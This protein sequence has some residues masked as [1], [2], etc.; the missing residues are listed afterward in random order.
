V[1]IVGT[2]VIIKDVNGNNIS[3]SPFITDAN[4]QINPDILMSVYTAS[5]DTPGYSAN[6]YVVDEKEDKYPFTITI[7][8]SGYQTYTDVF[9]H[10]ANEEWEIALQLYEGIYNN[11]VE[12]S[13]D[14]E[15]I[16]GNISSDLLS[17]TI[18]SSNLGGSVSSTSIE[19][20]ITT[21][22]LNGNI[23]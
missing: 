19:G 22:T 13:I 23:D 9:T 1:A 18:S 11:N 6:T 15:D 3:G 4:G 17:S 7:A 16:I 21:S 20:E 12:G 10:N 14:T 5:G 2:S 8:E